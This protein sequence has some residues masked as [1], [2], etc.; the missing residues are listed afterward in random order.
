[1]NKEILIDWL[2]D[3]YRMEHTVLRI[4]DGYEIDAE[5]Y[6]DLDII[7]RDQ[8]DQTRNQAERLKS[9][10]KRLGG[11]VT[12]F[13]SQELINMTSPF[14]YTAGNTERDRVV[15]NA[16]TQHAF[17]HFNHAAYLA[18]IETAKFF[19][20]TQTANLCRQI[21]AEDTAMAKVIEQKLPQVVKEFLNREN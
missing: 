17:E 7:I 8:R 18:L 4:L 15:K 13:E 3:A 14:Q 1:M 21:M 16:I 11:Q 6:R 9:E 2:N 12:E 10:I 19:G 5:E 20:E